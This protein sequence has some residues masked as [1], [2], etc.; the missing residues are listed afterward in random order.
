MLQMKSGFATFVLFLLICSTNSAQEA[1]GDALFGNSYPLEVRLGYAFREL[2][3]I[4][5]DKRYFPTYLHYRIEKETWDSV[6]IDI[7]ARGGFRRKNCFFTPLRVRIRAKERSGTLFED[8]KNLKLV[9]PCLPRGNAN[10][11]IIK[12]YLCY[13]LYE[14]ITPYYFNTKIMDLTLTD[15]RGRQSKSYKLKAFLIEDEDQVAKRM[16][17]KIMKAGVINPFLLQDTAAVRHDFFQYMIANTDWSAVAP[18]NIRILQVPPRINIPIP[19]DFDM[20]GL[21]NAPY[22]EVS[23]FLPIASVRERLYRGFC[24]GEGLFQFVRAEYLSFEDQIRKILRE[25]E[26]DIP[27]AEMDSLRRFLD[28]YFAILKNDQHFNENIVS[29]CRTTR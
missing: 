20:A 13:K 12:E 17:G 24:R 15:Q 11:L 9:L 7:R 2:K 4:H 1:P 8:H 22:A 14:L 5:S 26:N 29:K 27:P 25:I 16:G 19:Y 21:V 18:H 3:K 23:D 10:D 28:A 6:K